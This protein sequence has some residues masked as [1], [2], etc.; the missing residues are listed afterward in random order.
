MMKKIRLIVI[1]VGKAVETASRIYME[2]ENM[3]IFFRAERINLY[4][5]MIN[6]DSEM[7]TFTLEYT[8]PQFIY[9]D[10]QQKHVRSNTHRCSGNQ[11]EA[12][13]YC[14]QFLSSS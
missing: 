10:Q 11:T 2:I 1:K 8:I 4:N 5:L 3:N 12:P 7:N 9:S 14:L 6:V 13:S